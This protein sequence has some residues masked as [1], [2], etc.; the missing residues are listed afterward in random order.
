[1][2]K[3][4][5]NYEA[6]IVYYNAILKKKIP[7]DYRVIPYA[8]FSD[9]EIASVGLLEDEAIQK[10]GADN[11]LIGFTRYDDTAKGIAMGLKD[12]FVKVIIEKSRM[13]I[14]GAHIIGPQASVLI[15]EFITIL[16]SPEPA[17][18]AVTGTMHIH[19]AL[20]ELSV[21]MWK[22]DDTGRIS[23]RNLRAGRAGGTGI[24]RSLFPL[25]MERIE[26]PYQADAPKQGVIFLLMVNGNYRKVV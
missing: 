8:V 5:A 12:Y 14:L 16:S 22:P 15:Q 11:I 23:R 4:V 26:L 19:P 7:V 17:L 6:R 24:T 3:H 20:S 9:P 13:N 1:M 2:F 18:G 21:G 25:P 10:Y